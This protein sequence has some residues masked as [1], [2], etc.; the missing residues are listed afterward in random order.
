MT[1]VGTVSYS[2]DSAAV[3]ASVNKG[4]VRERA[5]NENAMRT[6]EALRRADRGDYAAARELI[7][8]NHANSVQVQGAI[9][10]D[11]KLQA[12]A[13]M[14]I[15]NSMKMSRDSYDSR[16][17]KKMKTSSFQLFNQQKLK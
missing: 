12:D 5:L 15:S 1:A 10:V 9:G 3:A 11:A 2:L 17:R 7:M 16:E 13:E 14:Q 8:M 4:V 6:E